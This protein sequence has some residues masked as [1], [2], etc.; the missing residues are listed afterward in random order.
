M[1]RTIDSAVFWFL[2]DSPL[3]F[4]SGVSISRDLFGLVLVPFFPFFFAFRFC[5]FF[6][7]FLSK[8]TFCLG[9]ITACNFSFDAFG[10]V[11]FCYW[12]ELLGWDRDLRNLEFAVGE[13]QIGV[14]YSCHGC[15]EYQ[16]LF[17]IIPGN[18]TG[19][20]GLVI[21]VVVTGPLDG[22]LFEEELRV[23]FSLFFPCFAGFF[24]FGFDSTGY[25][26]WHSGVD[27][28]Q[29]GFDGGRFCFFRIGVFASSFLK[30]RWGNI[31][32]PANVFGFF[33]FYSVGVVFEGIEFVDL[34]LFHLRGD[35]SPEV[36][37]DGHVGAVEFCSSHA[38][39]EG[40]DVFEHDISVGEANDVGKRVL[41]G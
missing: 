7:G 30:G 25:D 12:E 1:V 34:G 5:G 22:F 37:E 24:L 3:L 14:C 16:S 31:G 18:K 38:I 35:V 19:L 15:D 26:T 23:V 21:C 20:G 29:D 4:G 28:F 10:Y 32:F 11:V 33:V 36:F 13:G 9:F 8:R 39:L 41:W 40:G 27:A 2:W 17:A 6:V